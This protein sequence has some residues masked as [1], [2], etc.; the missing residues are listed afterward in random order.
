MSLD[1]DA[2]SRSMVREARS[3]RCLTVGLIS[4]SRQRNDRRAIDRLPQVLV[5]QLRDAELDPRLLLVRLDV[6]VVSRLSANSRVELSGPTL[7]SRYSHGEQSEPELNESPLGR[8]LQVDVPMPVGETASWTL[9]RLPRWLA[10]WKEEFS[11]ILLDL[12]PICLVPSR[13]IGRLCHKN[14]V[15]LGPDPCG[16]H[17]WILRHVAWHHESG[18]N[19]CGTLVTSI[20]A[21]PMVA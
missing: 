5:N 2:W 6:F 7:E 17:E 15:L 14:F 4:G 18:S 19:I 21:Q 8:W 16:S 13:I 11:V 20:S 12:G 1:Y 9:Q 3:N 10:K